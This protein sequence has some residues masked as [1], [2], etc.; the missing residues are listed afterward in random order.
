MSSEVAMRMRELLDQVR[1]EMR[2]LDVLRTCAAGGLPLLTAT[3]FEEQM[4]TFRAS[5]PGEPAHADVD[6]AEED[7]DNERVVADGL[8]RLVLPPYVRTEL[9][10]LEGWFLQRT[11]SEKRF[12][13]NRR[14]G[15]RKGP[16][17]EFGQKALDIVDR[18]VA[19]M[20]DL[21]PLCI[22]CSEPT[23][24]FEF[25]R[26]QLWMVAMLAGEIAIP[27][28]RAPI[29]DTPEEVANWD[30]R[31]RREAEAILD[32]YT[33]VAEEVAAHLGEY[34]ED[35]FHEGFNHRWDDA[36]VQERLRKAI[37]RAV[38]PW[39]LTPIVDET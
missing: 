31:T 17:D 19:I 29:V 13:L 34:T 22:A 5:S 14:G 23:G 18:I 35:E 15:R 21:E 25:R 27:G 37:H 36:T 7:G 16:L 4:R 1:A 12:E 11:G 32:E 3:T 28:V 26:L 24:A 38:E 33:R 2:W 39:V 10:M 20:A 9:E 6:D 30:R 8:A